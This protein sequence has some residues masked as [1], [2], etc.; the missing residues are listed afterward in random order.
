VEFEEPKPHSKYTNEWQESTEA[1]GYSGF[2][3]HPV[4]IS[5]GETKIMKFDTFKFFAKLSKDLGQ[6]EPVLFYN[7]K[8]FISTR[9]NLINGIWEKAN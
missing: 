9:L 2:V 7:N 8:V 1:L 6:C 5:P 3:P 4:V